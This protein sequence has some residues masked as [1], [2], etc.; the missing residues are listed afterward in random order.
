MLTFVLIGCELN[1]EVSSKEGIFQY[2]QSY[3]GDNGAVGAIINALPHPVQTEHF[4]LQTSEEPYGIV[5]KYEPTDP[6]QID[7]SFKELML[8]NAT[9]IFTLV[10]NADVVTFDYERIKYTLTRERLEEWYEQ[11][12]LKILNEE[13][14]TRL[15]EEQLTSHEGDFDSLFY[16]G[17]V[18]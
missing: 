6:T 4:A 11:D 13:L 16:D 10:H 3:V 17:E 15:I 1:N 14:L 9:Y 18:E 7:D 8:N 12:L 5:V 2:Q